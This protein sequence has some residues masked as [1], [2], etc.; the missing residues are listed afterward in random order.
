MK[1]LWEQEI[2]RTLKGVIS[3]RKQ[4]GEKFSQ[5]S[6][7]ACFLSEQSKACLRSSRVVLRKRRS[8]S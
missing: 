3:Q 1:M 6:E 5:R 8:H 4:E 2:E 7:G